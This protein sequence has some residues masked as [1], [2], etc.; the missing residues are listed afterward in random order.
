MNRQNYDIKK[1]TFACHLAARQI[2]QP[3]KLNLERSRL[4]FYG[5]YLYIVVQAAFIIWNVK[6]V[7]CECKHV[8]YCSNHFRSIKTIFHICTLH[9]KRILKMVH[10]IFLI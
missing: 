10:N 2:L 3:V 4:S 1:S 5:N 9:I 6:I 8:D 7:N